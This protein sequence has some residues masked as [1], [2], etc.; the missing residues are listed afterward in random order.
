MRVDNGRQP[1]RLPSYLRLALLVQLGLLLAGLL[2]LQVANPGGWLA[3]L[4][5][6]SALNLAAVVAGVLRQPVEQAEPGAGVPVPRRP[7][8]SGPAAEPVATGEEL[9]R[10][11]LKTLEHDLARREQRLE[12]LTAGRDRARQESR[13]KSDYLALLGRELQPLKGRLEVLLTARDEPPLGAAQRHALEELGER[14][15][16]LAV[17]LEDISGEEPAAAEAAP[18]R[19]ANRVLIVDDGPVN[20]MLAR[21]VLERQGLEVRTATSGAEALACLDQVPFDLVLMDIFMPGMDGMEASRRWRDVEAERYPDHRSVLVALTANASEEDRQRFAEA[22]LDDYL[23]KPYRPQELIE[24]VRRW[25][26]AHHHAP[27]TP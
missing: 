7:L 14:L 15:G 19:R 8:P 5:L 11:R 6:A 20:L 22:G 18:A 1:R 24:L 25:L 9:L 10:R 2:A 12:R 27:D 16:D 3:A 23:A 17:L 21:Q 26:P 4:L 13:L